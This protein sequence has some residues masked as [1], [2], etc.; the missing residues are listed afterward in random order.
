MFSIRGW[1]YQVFCDGLFYRG[2]AA[3]GL[4]HVVSVYTAMLVVSLIPPAPGPA[5]VLKV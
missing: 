5:L 2:L 4:Q 1:F 3:A